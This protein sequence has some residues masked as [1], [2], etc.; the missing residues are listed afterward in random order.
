[1]KKTDNHWT[2]ER[3]RNFFFNRKLYIEKKMRNEILLNS[4]SGSCNIIIFMKLEKP[5]EI[6]DLFCNMEKTRKEKIHIILKKIRGRLS[7]YL[8]IYN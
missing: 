1:M 4:Y 5:Q 8:G 3:M 7:S 2:I 6:Y